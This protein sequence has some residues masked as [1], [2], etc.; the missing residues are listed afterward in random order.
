M[1][2]VKEVEES[3]WDKSKQKSLPAS[4]HVVQQRINM[5]GQWEKELNKVKVIAFICIISFVFL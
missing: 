3:G 2:E 1:V 5:K 4:I